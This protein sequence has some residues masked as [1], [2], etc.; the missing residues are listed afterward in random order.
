MAKAFGKLNVG[1]LYDDTLDSSDGV[2]H[3]VKTIGSWLSSKGHKVIYLV[4]QTKTR[5]WSGG[6]VYSLAKNQKVIFN[7]NR[8]SIPRLASA[9]GIKEIL[10]TEKLDILHVQMPYSP[11][12]AMRVINRADKHPAIVGTFHIFP[13]GLASRW[14]S[15]FLRLMYGRSLSRFDTVMSVS[16]AAQ[17]FARQAFGINSEVLPNVV[18][19]QKLHSQSGPNKSDYLRI[20]FLGRLV[21]RKGAAQLLQ[22]FLI[23][24]NQL[25][26]VRLTIAGDGPQKTKLEQFVRKNKLTEAVEFL[27]FINES[28]KAPLLASAN[29]A[30]FP[31]LYGESFGIVL[32]EAMAAGAGVVLGG[33][34]PGYQSVLGEQ[35]VLLVNP[36]KTNEFAQ[37]LQRLIID[38][39]LAKDLHE[40]QKQH[41]KQYDIDIVGEKLV[42]I[43]NRTIANKTRS[44]HNKNTPQNEILRGPR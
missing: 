24:H 22:A 20:V 9:A 4:G 15:Y 23:L 32:I 37:R 41:V 30:C 36:K 28:D 31:S 25:P 21:S 26:Q 7:G 11:L 5:E 1:F 12:M 35:L 39:D 40:W 29:I 2:A 10:H 6:K 3:Q 18:D 17:K 19:F 34:N 27:G 13:A 8:L 14:G 33:N 44:G 42:N 16:S 38:K 43:Y